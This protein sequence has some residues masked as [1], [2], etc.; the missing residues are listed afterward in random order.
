[1]GDRDACVV[2]CVRVHPLSVVLS[3]SLLHVQENF[4]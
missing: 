2:E 1:M 4:P 3:D